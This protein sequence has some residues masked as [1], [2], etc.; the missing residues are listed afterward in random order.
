MATTLLRTL[1]DLEAVYGEP[2]RGSLMKEIDHLSPHYRAFVEHA[3]FVL[4]ASAG[5][6]G[7]DCS[8]RGDAPGF[9]TV[10]DERTLLLP[11]RRGNNRVDTLRNVVEDPRVALL[12]L[13]PGVGETLRVNG[14]AEIDVD[15]ELLASFAVQ[16]KA[17]R[18]VLRVHVERVYFQCQKAL[19]RSRLWEPESR[20]ERSQLPST[21]EILAALDREVD[22]AAYDAAYPERMRQTIY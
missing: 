8:P 7:L 5:P 14:T 9:V 13:V 22:A 11:D 12:F 17:P 19:A 2:V 4:V 10:A 15:P 20:I 21:G 16:G 1:A 3:P 6:G 18:S